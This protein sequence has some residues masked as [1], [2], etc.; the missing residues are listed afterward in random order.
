MKQFY[1]SVVEV[2]WTTSIVKNPWLK[3]RMGLILIRIIEK[4]KKQVFFLDK[5]HTT[6]SESLRLLQPLTSFL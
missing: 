6:L 4:V 3:G 2:G 5:S 1:Q